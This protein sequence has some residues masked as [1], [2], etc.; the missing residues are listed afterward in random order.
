MNGA[1]ERTGAARRALIIANDTYDH[2]S[3]AS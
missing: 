3:P 1:A 2:A